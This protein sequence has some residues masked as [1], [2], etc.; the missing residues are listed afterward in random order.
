MRAR[1][2]FKQPRVRAVLYNN[3]NNAHMSTTNHRKRALRSDNGGGSGDGTYQPG[4]TLQVGSVHFNAMYDG[5]TIE[6]NEE[7]WRTNYSRISPLEV[8]TFAK[9]EGVGGGGTVGL[10]SM[11]QNREVYDLFP[12]EPV[13]VCTGS[14]MRQRQFRH[15]CFV[16]SSLNHMCITNED[17]NSMAKIPGTALHA[18]AMR[19][20]ASGDG[21][22]VVSKITD[23]QK[24]QILQHK[25]QTRFVGFSVGPMTNEG[26]RKGQKPHV[27]CNAGGLMSVKADQCIQSGQYVV[28]DYPL[29][30]LEIPGQQRT[31]KCCTPH[32]MSNAVARGHDYKHLASKVTMIVR[33]LDPTTDFA[34]MSQPCAHAGVGHCGSKYPPWVVGQC[35]RGCAKPGDTIDLRY[36]AEIRYPRYITLLSPPPV[37]MNR[38][39]GKSDGGGGGGSNNSGNSGTT[40]HDIYAASMRKMAIRANGSGGGGG[41]DHDDRATVDML[42]SIDCQDIARHMRDRYAAHVEGGSEDDEDMYENVHELIDPTASLLHFIDKT[43]E[44]AND[45]DLVDVNK[46]KEE[47]HKALKAAVVMG[48]I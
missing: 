22:N 35:V 11:V 36:S 20:A 26:Y 33:P 5:E 9:I 41:D 13:F 15:G 25:Y 19:I 28:V 43:I 48:R 38:Q 3:I 30:N 14:S 2:T 37:Y 32:W 27:A 17:I 46:V 8:L 34:S 12:N 6:A 47:I 24:R 7:V 39:L 40:L 21:V 29:E 1:I 45:E 18:T 16:L 23:E 31:N 4:P 10:H 42:P 44:I